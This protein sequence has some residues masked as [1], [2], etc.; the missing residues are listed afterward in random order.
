M[1]KPMTKTAEQ[2]SGS[3]PEISV[4]VRANAGTGKTRVLTDRVLR[5]LLGKTP[6]SRILCLTFTK[7]AAAEMAKRVYDEL[8]IWARMEDGALSKALLNLHGTQVAAEDLDEARRLFAQALDVPGGL[9]IQTIH[10][11]CESLLSRFPIEAGI[12]PHFRVMDE[13]T[14]AELLQ[15]A[16]EA[17]YWRASTAKDKALANALE[18]IT[19]H[20]AEGTFTDALDA[21]LRDRGKFRR[22]LSRHGGADGMA[23][24]TATHLGLAPGEDEKTVLDAAACEDAFDG[25]GL[26]NVVVALL[27]GDK[28]DAAHGEIIASWLAAP[29]RVVDFDAYLGAF[30]KDGGAGER[31]KTLAYSKTVKRCPDALDILEVEADR[32]EAVRDRRNA[33]LLATAT[34]ALLQFA[35]A[36]L[37]T[38]DGL[39]QKAALLDYDDLIFE[40]RNLLER[41]GI[42]P[43][44]L[45]KLDGGI[46]HIL[47][48]EAQDTNPDQWRVIAMLASEFFAGQGAREEKRTVFSVGDVK[49]SIF[50][51]QRADPFFFGKM[52]DHFSSRVQQAGEGWRDVPLELSFRSAP[53]ILKAVDA[54][55]AQADARDGVSLEGEKIDHGAAR[56]GQAGLVEIWPVEPR[57]ERSAATPWPLPLAQIS[58]DLP[59]KRLAQKIARQI[60]KWIDTKEQLSSRGRAIRPGDILILVR[61]RGP[62]FEEIVRA[63]KRQKI[64]VAGMDRMVLTDH[65]AVRDLIALGRFVLLPEDDLALAIVLKSPLV[66]LDETALFD[67]AY[68]RK[69]SLWD[70]LRMR[71]GE[72]EDFAAAHEML[73]A[74]L[75]RADYIPPFEFYA[76]LLGSLGA[77]ER[78]IAR[79]GSEAN[80]PIDEFLNLSFAYEKI[81]APSMEGFLHWVEAGKAE[82]KRDL[83]QGRDEVRVMT[84]HGAKGLEAPIVFL[85]DTCQVPDKD[86]PLFWFGDEDEDAATAGVLWVPRRAHEEK[87]ARSLREAQA[88]HREREYR[89]LL[90]VAMTRA[91]D[92][93]Y[94]AGWESKKS[95][96]PGCWYDLIGKGLATLTTSVPLAMGLDGR[97]FEAD[98]KAPADKGEDAAAGD[99]VT[100]AAFNADGVPD[101]ARSPASPAAPPLPDLRPSSVAGDAPAIRSPIGADQGR[102]FQ[103]GRI[104]HSQLQFLPDVALAGRL[105]ACRHYLSQKN[106]NLDLATQKALA[107]EVLAVLQAGEFAPLFGSNSRAEVPIVGEINGR[108]ISG[109]VDRLLVTKTSVFVIDYKTQ[110]TPPATPSATPEIY[111]RQMAAYVALLEKIYPERRVMA[112]LLWTDGPNLVPL[113]EKLLRPYAP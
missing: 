19:A 88:L 89:R 8:G 45:F 47:V 87:T 113:K 38:F 81:H 74:S 51:F 10:S 85:P 69:G 60:G 110:R 50:S 103:R 112:A 94:I 6:P 78:L 39:K 53:V 36:L 99:E 35:S 64:P 48:D 11:F 24:V 37:E 79:L 4:W 61:R 111:L 5:L 27:E 44:V 30:F 106:F 67:L 59:E 82:I 83:E 43:W 20:V 101:W 52:R 14:T 42:A 46:D 34:H 13:R 3:N 76:E 15:N 84:V 75:A 100:G 98:Q 90:Y 91:E 109:Q 29:D 108:V 32:L 86:R 96:N 73:S 16:R 68:D 9:K 77:R 40:A 2:K 18:I 25:T 21:L 1:K 31:F 33:A 63:L 56:K 92:R 12:A 22:G 97:R 28:K 57:G 93:L 55:F 70:A 62:F 66:G 104:V 17:V 107:D 71:C 102:G 95:R 7:A 49:Q 65:L 41:E 105:A 72:R 23:L 54:V 80:D 58:A 26:R